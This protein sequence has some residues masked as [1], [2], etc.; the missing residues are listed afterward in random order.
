M[1]AKRQTG[2]VVAF[3]A[4]AVAALSA[5]PYA[6]GWNDG[7]RLAC[8]ESLADQ[9][10]FI[11]DHS[12]FVRVP[13]DRSPYAPHA[14][15]LHE[16]GTRDKLY[17]NGHYYSDKP[18]VIS[19][20]LAGL[21]RGLVWL[22]VPRL[23]D[24][25]GPAIWWLNFLTS[26]LA[27]TITLLALLRLGAHVGLR[28]HILWLWLASAGGATV[29][30]PYAQ[31]VNNHE[32][33]LAVVA[34]SVALVATT[35]S[36]W[37]SQLLLGT[38]LG[39]GYNLDLAAGPLWLLAGLALAGLNWQAGV[40]AAWAAMPWVLACHGL[41]YAL[42]GVI[43][44]LNAVPAYFLWPGSPFSPSNLTGVWRGQWA[45]KFVYTLALL[46]GKPG[47]IWHN[48]PLVLLAWQRRWSGPLLLALGWCGATWVVY[49]LLSNNYGGACCSVRWFV[50]FVVPGFWALAVLL[51]ERPEL[52]ASF[53]ALTLGGAVLAGI[54]AW[55]GPWHPRLV[56]GY[57]PIVAGTLVLAAA[58]APPGTWPQWLRFAK[59][60]LWTGR[61]V[62]WPLAQGRDHA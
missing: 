14:D 27:Y 12:I 36:S 60:S 19:V 10:T 46:F 17:I 55:V 41:N 4:L 58:L 44:P 59:L 26:G 21:Y 28:G 51:R 31:Y 32:L 24:E 43:G 7:S 50:P 9:G 22:G 56:P 2:F 54:M 52:G 11:I 39:V 38:L 6:G 30:L 25:P 18:P 61:L 29:T 33:L 42:G 8:V 20:L 57:W 13:T 49:A 45:E 37:R 3:I 40:W 47:F 53:A 23:A 62:R 35:E 15:A 34:A 1:N 16:H 5:R 48:L